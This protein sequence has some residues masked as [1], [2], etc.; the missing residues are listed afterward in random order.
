[1][2][3]TTPP[4]SFEAGLEELEKI[5]KEMESGDLPLE[6]AILLFEKGMQVSEACR[7]QLA[8]AETRVEMLVRRGQQLV[9]EPLENGQ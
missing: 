8:E 5:V 3:E 9:A 6:R 7:K 1:M 2:P 4:A